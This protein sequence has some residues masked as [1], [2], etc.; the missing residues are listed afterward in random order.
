MSDIHQNPP[1]NLTVYNTAIK[2]LGEAREWE[3]AINL[4]AEM[5]EKGLQPDG[6]S[7]RAALSSYLQ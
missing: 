3:K 7:F 1:R 2:A 4:V 5:R 6:A